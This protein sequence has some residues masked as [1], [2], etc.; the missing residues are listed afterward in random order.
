[1]PTG[2]IVQYSSQGPTLGPAVV[3]LVKPL[4]VGV[5]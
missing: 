4:T 3:A 1:V 2:I 5:L